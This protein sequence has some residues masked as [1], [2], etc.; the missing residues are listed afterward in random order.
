MKARRADTL[1]RMI[2]DTFS[3]R[4]NGQVYVGPKGP[5][6]FLLSVFY[7]YVGPNGH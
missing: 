5:G 3:N 6:T 2:N 1:Y 4:S 7:E